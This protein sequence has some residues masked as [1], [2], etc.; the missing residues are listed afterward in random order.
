MK[1]EYLAHVAFNI[2]SSQ[3]ASILTKNIVKR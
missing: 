2:L 1:Y 3:N